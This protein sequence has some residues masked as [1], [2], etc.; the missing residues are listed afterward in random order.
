MSKLAWWRGIVCWCVL[1]GT[2]ATG[3]WAQGFKSLVSL[4]GANGQQPYYGSLVQC[5]DGNLYGTTYGGG[6]HAA[7]SI[8]RMT[9]GGTLTTF[10]S[11]CSQANCADGSGPTAGLALAANGTLYG[12][13]FAGGDLNCAFPSGCGT[14]FKITPAGKL[15]TLHTFVGNGD[16]AGPE[17]GLA[18]GPNGN[19]YGTTGFVG[20]DGTIFEIT[21]GG[22]L[23]TLHFFDGTDGFGPYDTLALGS[24]GNFYGTTYL[25]GTSVA[26]NDGCGTIFEISSTG[27][28]SSVLSFDFAD[29]AYPVAGLVQAANGNLYGTT[30]G[31]GASSLCV[32][33]IAGCGTV[34]ELTPAGQLTTLYNFCSQTGCTDGGNPYSTLVQATDGNL[35]GTT[36]IGGASTL[37]EDNC[38]SIFKITPGG[39]LTTLHSFD[40]ADGEYPFDGLIQGTNGILYGTTDLGGTGA[41]PNGCGTAFSDGVA[42]GS[43]VE[44]VP[45]SGKV[46]TTVAILGNNLKGATGVTFNGTAATFTASS[47]NIKTTV[48]GGATTGFVQVTTP[49]GTLTSNVKFRIP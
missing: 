27:S 6:A 30:A 21:P 9:P 39:V 2:P 40:G 4:N 11:F 14:V 16:G 22:S 48:P 5:I 44:T 25:G 20:G 10:Y 28:F 43:F 33:S 23:T 36:Y 35:Y 24:N 8:F 47:S 15:T 17:G 46:G 31:G 12:T 34:F 7:G 42:L 37:C 18:L 19:F 32:A 41:C 3:L 29:G 26:C 49:H 45:A 1:L 38:G 13:T